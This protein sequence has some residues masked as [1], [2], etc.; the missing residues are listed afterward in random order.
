MIRRSENFIRNLIKINKMKIQIIDHQKIKKN[1]DSILIYFS[2]LD[3]NVFTENNNLDFK[4][5]EFLQRFSLDE[6]E[7]RLFY[8]REDSFLIFNVGNRRD[9]NLKKFSLSISRSLR[10]VKSKKFSYVIFNLNNLLIDNLEVEYLIEKASENI[11]LAEY[12]FNKYKSKEE[13]FKIKEISFLMKGKN[14]DRGIQRGVI[15]G[16]SVNFARDLS[17]TPGG[18]MTPKILS[19]TAVNEFKNKK[20][21]KIDVLDK[22]KLKAMKMGGL[23]GVSQG[24]V[25]DPQMIVVSYFGNKNKKEV[26]IAFVGKG[27]TFDSGGLNIKAGDSMLDM[28]MDMSGGAAVLGSIKAISDLKIPLNIICVVPAAENMPSHQSFRPGDLLK[29]YSGKIIEVKNT[30]AEGRIILADALSFVSLNIK[31]KMIVDVATLTGAAVVALGYRA[32]ALFTNREHLESDLK[33]IGYYSGDYVWPLPLWDDY[34]EEIKG[35]FGDISNMGNKKGAGG[36]IIGAVFLKNF[37]DDYPWIH[38]D[39]APTMASIENQGMAKGATGTGVRFLVGL[40]REFKKISK[41]L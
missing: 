30:D 20:Y 15:I 28:H 37:V 19:S 4:I 41:E 29:S 14:F 13:F 9:W 18:E 34:Q 31:P 23:L 24:S 22:K 33:N 3:E 26:D 32:I 8:D 35:T 21:I 11:I 17:N 16:R 36:A 38:L 7:M 40:A 25:E 12:D 2:F 39:I 27:L 10:E 6:G 5:K 1:K